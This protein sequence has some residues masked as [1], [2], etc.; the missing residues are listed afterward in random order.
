MYNK[1]NDI[2]KAL[3]NS[4]KLKLV[5]YFSKYWNY[6]SVITLWQSKDQIHIILLDTETLE[7]CIR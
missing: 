6:E 5:N 2:L 4:N 7:W 3:Q 1:K